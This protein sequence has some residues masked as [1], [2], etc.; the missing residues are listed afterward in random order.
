MSW[1][2]IIG[3]ATQITTLIN[4]EQFF[5]LLIGPLSPGESA[6]V[7]MELDPIGSTDDVQV[8]LY[9][10]LEDTGENWDDTPFQ[11]LVIPATPDPSKISF[12]IYGRFKVRIGVI[13]L[14]STDSHTSCDMEYRRDGVSV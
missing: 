4:T 13:T 9:G 12:T 2:A 6:E 7:H 10:A 14:G 3:P 8:N 5:D 11:S 1:S